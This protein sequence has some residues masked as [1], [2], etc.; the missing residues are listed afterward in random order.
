[1]ALPDL[2]QGQL[3]LVVLQQLH[4]ERDAGLLLPDVAEELRD[5]PVVPG[6]GRVNSLLWSAS[7]ILRHFNFYYERAVSSHPSRAGWGSRECEH[8]GRSGQAIESWGPIQL[9]RGGQ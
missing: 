4:V 9:P 2:L 6:L 5:L 8:K 3:L 1:M 7:F